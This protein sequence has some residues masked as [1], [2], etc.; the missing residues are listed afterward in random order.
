MAKKK[1]RSNRCM[2]KGCN[3]KTKSGKVTKTLQFCSPHWRDALRIRKQRNACGRI[4][5]KNPAHEDGYCDSCRPYDKNVVPFR[6]DWLRGENLRK[7][8]TYAHCMHCKEK[9][10][11]GESNCCL[12]CEDQILQILQILV[13]K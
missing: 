3:K 10:H 6:E 12:D 4:N 5:C 8:N 9:L 13:E 2:K 7:S 1:T 11:G